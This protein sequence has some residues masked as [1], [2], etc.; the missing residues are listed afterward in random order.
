MVDRDLWAQLRTL[1]AAGAGLAEQVPG[2]SG[3]LVAEAIAAP[4]EGEDPAIDPPTERHRRSYVPR[5]GDD[6]RVQHGVGPRLPHHHH[7]IA[8]HVVV[9]DAALLQHLVGIC[10]RLLSGVDGQHPR[11]GV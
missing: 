6:R 10:D 7:R 3:L 5:V 1:Q 8:G 4:L 9:G 11:H 2:R